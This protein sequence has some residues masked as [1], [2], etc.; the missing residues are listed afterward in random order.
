LFYG[1]RKK[2][3]GLS[4]LKGYLFKQSESIHPAKDG[5]DVLKW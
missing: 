4:G 2:P 1:V 3:D 5:C